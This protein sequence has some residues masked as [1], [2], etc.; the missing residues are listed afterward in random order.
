VGKKLPAG[1]VEL[2]DR[3]TK[4]SADIPVADAAR[5]IPVA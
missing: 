5:K 2:V 3:R 4:A 1:L